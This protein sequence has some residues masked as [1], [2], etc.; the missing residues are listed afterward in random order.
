MRTGTLIDVLVVLVQ[1]GLVLCLSVTA[2][3]VLVYA[4]GLFRF[5]RVPSQDERPKPGR[6]YSKYQPEHIRRQL[7]Q[8][9][10]PR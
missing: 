7:R 1:I 2:A 8:L 10:W 4:I 3:L 6:V 9:Y 5:G